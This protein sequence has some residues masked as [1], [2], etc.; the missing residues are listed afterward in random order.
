[1]DLLFWFYIAD[2]QTERGKLFEGGSMATEP[3]MR[4][5]EEI[6]AKYRNEGVISGKSIIEL[7]SD[8]GR[9]GFT[10]FSVCRMPLLQLRMQEISL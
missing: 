8:L 2:K 7:F 9:I 6:R 4:T 1:M 5:A 10:L 3:R